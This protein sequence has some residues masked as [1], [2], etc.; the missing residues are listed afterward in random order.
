MRQKNLI[1]LLFIFNLGISPA[2]GQC[3]Q[4][5]SLWA[6]LFFLKN[7]LVIRTQDKLSEMLRYNA[8]DCPKGYDSAHAY[9]LQ[10][11][12]TNYYKLGEYLKAIDYTRQS[13]DIIKARLG[14]PSINPKSLVK[15]YYNLEFYYNLL[16]QEHSQM[17]AIDSCIFYDGRFNTDYFY[18]C[19]LMFE[20]IKHLYSRGD[21]QR[22]I[23]YATIAGSL[24]QKYYHQIDSM[25]YINACLTYK[26]DALI[27]SDQIPVA[28]K[29]LENKV[30]ECKKAGDSSFYGVL[31]ALLGFVNTRKMA[32]SQAVSSFQ[33]AYYW[34]EK[35]KFRKGCAQ[36]LAQMGRLYSDK[37]I[38]AE[39]SYSTFGK[40]L[41][42]AD[43]IDSLFILDKIA[44]LY[45]RQNKFDSAFIF[46]QRAFD[47]VKKGIDERNIFEGPILE[48][49][50]GNNADDV[51]ALIL[52]KGDAC[53][54]RF[55]ASKEKKSGEQAI[56]IYK[57]ADKLLDRIR[58]E[59]SELKSKLSWRNNMI[60]L[61]EYAIETCYLTDN[62]H[63]ALYF[64]EKSRAVV[65]NDQLNERHWVKE[66]DILQQ[67]QSKKK[68]LSLEKELDTV[69]ISS[70]VYIDLQKELLRQKQNL[71][72]W[73][74]R[75]KSA[76]PLYYQSFL[77]TSVITV[78]DIQRTILKDR[79]ALV[80]LFNG[81]SAVYCL[82]ISA[83]N[84]RL[85]RIDKADFDRTVNA[86]IFY[87]SHADLL[88]GDI[89]GYVQVSWHLYQLLFKNNPV[90]PG[91]IIVS[92][93]GRYFPF[94]ALLSTNS[95]KPLIY[96]LDDHAVSYTYSARYL[97]ND[98]SSGST[99]SSGNFLGLAPVQY[100]SHLHL[101]ML[102]GS[103]RSLRNIVPYVSAAENLLWKEASKNNFLQLFPGYKV[104]QLYT[105]AADSSAKG[106]P[107]IYFADSA[108]YLSELIP[109]HKPVAQLIVLAACETGNGKNY[110]G[111]GVFSFGRG[112]AALGIPSSVA[113][114]W[115]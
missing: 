110:Q 60:R 89:E 96:F 59:H 77:D 46:F 19:I 8:Q 76:N 6:R 114:L 29:L 105:H 12:G 93:D 7:N 99:A 42:Y 22:C 109:E 47:H 5:D 106:E 63:A 98:F 16:G 31:Y 65:L 69:L 43:G 101:P 3:L 25:D 100:A 48:K 94:E 36:S 17:N 35:L 86:Y 38:Q 40:A 27:F 82:I 74:T 80:E 113:N 11:I 53:L 56:R 107:A 1:L 73:L 4:G 34:N 115:G 58:S 30:E 37:L 78:Q 54:A 97:L 88:N 24:F 79:Q 111:E 70:A 95:T 83:G 81:D 84:T 71:D 50:I 62:Y 21:Y 52:D 10:S 9:L 61:Y 72:E 15:C 104:I 103:D 26:V 102:A 92:P 108:L 51:V 66:E 2:G 90:P 67:A 64:F 23:L 91:R 75:V 85:T 41:G 55:K 87:I 18:T 28:E 49:I 39:R 57:A 45:V 14:K 112:F 13:I 20:K 33:Q 32:Y 68:T 44:N